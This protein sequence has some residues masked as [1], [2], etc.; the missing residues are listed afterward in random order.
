MKVIMMLFKSE[1]F[2]SIGDVS[3]A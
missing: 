1:D 2:L 3:Q